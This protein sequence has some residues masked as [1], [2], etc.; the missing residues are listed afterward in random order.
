[1][2]L[3]DCDVPQTE[4]TESG[5]VSGMKV[6]V[7]NVQSPDVD[8]S[9]EGATSTSESKAQSLEQETSVD[10][11]TEDTVSEG[12]AKEETA[13]CTVEVIVTNPGE[14]GM[15]ILLYVMNVFC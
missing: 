14:E 3:V 4:T 8:A 10:L 13:K 12:E 6:Q 9:Q 5:S 11:L 7:E 15:Y 2:H 1:M